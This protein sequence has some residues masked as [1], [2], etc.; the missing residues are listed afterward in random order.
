MDGNLFA[1][2]TGANKGIGFQIA[3]LLLKRDYSNILITARNE[4]R[5]TQAR[6]QLAKN[7]PSKKIL[8]LQ[9]DVTDP[10]SIQ[11]AARTVREENI[12]LGAIIHNAGIWPPSA[13]LDQNLFG[14]A[15]DFKDTLAVNF[16]GVVAVSR[17]FIPHLATGG[18]IVMVGS[19][20]GPSYV[21]RCGAGPRATL[22]EM[23][24]PFSSLESLC[25]E[26]IAVAEKLGPDDDAEQAFQAVGLSSSAYGLT[27]AAVT[28]FAMVLARERPD[29]K[30]SSCSPGMIETDMVRAIAEKKGKKAEDWG[31][32]PVE[33]GALCPVYLTMDPVPSPPGEAWFFGSDMQ[34]SPLDRYRAPGSAPFCPQ[35]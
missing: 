29:L 22:T 12:R 16:Y 6:D 15:Q 19:G 3:A 5:G 2:I 20:M 14:S 9:L 34:R 33:K 31:A 7:F 21:E 17:A 27:K 8:F 13:H 32:L 24:V 28:A 1:L 10:Q 35:A 25:A 4:K 30:V 18:R 26:A 23:N 11:G